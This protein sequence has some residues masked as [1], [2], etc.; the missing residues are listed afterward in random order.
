[1]VHL[2]HVVQV[3][4]FPC[5]FPLKFY[6]DNDRLLEGGIW[7]EITVAHNDI[8]DD[9]YAFYIEEMRPIQLSRFDFDEYVQM[10]SF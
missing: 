3:Q 9:D 1:M 5:H 4:I 8:E 6:R 10:L 7:A 2:L